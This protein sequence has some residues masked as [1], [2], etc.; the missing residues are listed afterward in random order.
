MPIELPSNKKQT[1]FRHL[2]AWLAIAIYYTLYSTI[3]GSILVKTVWIFLLLVNYSFAYY[4]LVLFIWPK[5]LSEK[6]LLYSILVFFSV[7]FFCSF[8]Y[9]QLTVI[10]PGLGGMH[11]MIYWPFNEFINNAL[12]L[13]LYVFL[14][15]IGTYYNW[16]GIKKIEEDLKVDKNIIE[17]EFLFL[18][19]QFHSHLTFNFL[20]FCYNKI[21]EFSPLTSNSV[22]EFADML[23]YS[24]ISSLDRP[25]PLEREVEYIENYISFQK[26]INP[27]LNAQV[28][29]KGDLANINILPKALGAFVECFLKNWSFCSTKKPIIMTIECVQ[30]E[31][32]FKMRSLED[33]QNIFITNQ[34]LQNTKQILQSF[35]GNRYSLQILNNNNLFSCELKLE[36]CK[37]AT[38]PNHFQQI[39]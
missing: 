4:T 7:T 20:N 35:Y 1:L 22:E 31:I 26:F 17:M 14:S 6:K 24:L 18:K 2:A 28:N 19:N 34:E 12:K 5:I 29:C 27:N 10:T 3:E 15:S 30:N 37:K 16:V 38:I 9:F 8:F 36:N 21:R 11:P 33:K 25:V 13:F 39:Y 32:I 23:R